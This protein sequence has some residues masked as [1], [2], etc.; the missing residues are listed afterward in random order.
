VGIESTL[1]SGVLPTVL[2]TEI[3]E[4]VEY[5]SIVA[6][7]YQPMQ[8]LLSLRLKTKLYI[9][10]VVFL[11]IYILYSVFKYLFNKIKSSFNPIRFNLKHVMVIGGSDGLGKEIVREVFMKGALVS[12]VGR[13][14]HKMKEIKDQLDT[15]I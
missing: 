13:D 10:V 14:E 3:I 9:A 11:I 12:I 6:W 5:R 1:L 7:F 8:F 2:P 15:S 4:N